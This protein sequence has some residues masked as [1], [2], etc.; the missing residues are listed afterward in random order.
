MYMLFIVECRS[1]YNYI[2][3]EGSTQTTASV[4]KQPMSRLGQARIVMHLRIVYLEG[5]R[6][7]AIIT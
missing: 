5:K 4:L 7:A 1:F 2:R 3:L 6:Q